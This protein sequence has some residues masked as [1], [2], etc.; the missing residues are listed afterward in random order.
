M[1]KASRED[2]GDEDGLGEVRKGTT[3]VHRGEEE[4]IKGGGGAPARA[5][6]A[7]YVGSGRRCCKGWQES[8][9]LDGSLWMVG[10]SNSPI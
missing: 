5:A 10:P 2:A 7:M 6:A 1:S 8:I 3:A 4:E 9:D